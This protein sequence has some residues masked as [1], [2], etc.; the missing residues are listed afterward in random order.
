MDASW[1]R[2]IEVHRA[3]IDEIFSSLKSTHFLPDR[4]KVFRALELP[5]NRVRAI[6]I[7]QDPYPT[8]G[9]AEGLAFSVSR[10]VTRLPAS[11]KNI[12]AE[13]R[14]DL[15]LPQPSSGHLGKW[16]DEGVL[17]LNQILTVAPHKPLAHKGLGWETI[18]QSLLSSFCNSEIP[19]ICWG[20]GAKSAALKA[21]IP[22]ANLFASAHPSPLSAYRGFFG[23]RPF[24]RVNEYLTTRDC[25]PIDW[26][27]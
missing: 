11:L 2:Y 1:N 19:V 10:E 6:I 22:E 12:F 27:L 3:L 16:H 15:R 14:D 4:S 17:L 7:G 8:P 9:M 26:T 5:Q 24:T 23:S 18:T 21:G 20:S 13:Y 25:E